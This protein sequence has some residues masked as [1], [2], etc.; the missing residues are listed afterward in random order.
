MRA[1]ALG[2]ALLAEMGGLKVA[3]AEAAPAPPPVAQN[4]S[5]TWERYPSSVSSS[6][7]LHRWRHF[8][9]SRRRRCCCIRTLAISIWGVWI[10]C[11]LAH[12]RI[13][14][15]SLSHNSRPVE[16]CHQRQ[17]DTIA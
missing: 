3:M 17:S 7:T 16:E 11:C 12:V 5:G 1:T 6:F 8:V 9:Y 4:F 14:A 15:A 13:H 10:Q 2:E